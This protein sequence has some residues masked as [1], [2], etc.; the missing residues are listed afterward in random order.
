MSTEAQ[1]VSSL[2]AKERLKDLLSYSVSE[3]YF[4]VRKHLGLE[5][6]P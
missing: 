1:P 6:R 5:V 3:E 4:A 2:P